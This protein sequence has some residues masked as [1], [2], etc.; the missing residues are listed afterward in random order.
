MTEKYFFRNEG[1][2]DTPVM[3]DEYYEIGN[4]DQLMWYLKLISG[5]GDGQNTA[6]KAKLVNDINMTGRVL[7]R[8][9]KEFIGEFDG[10]GH[11]I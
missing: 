2:S 11:K 1:E 10:N 4:A 3:V 7:P 9:T 6:A 5:S 8:N